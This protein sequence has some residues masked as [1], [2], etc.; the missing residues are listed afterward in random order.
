MVH[1]EQRTVLCY[2]VYKEQSR[3]RPGKTGGGIDDGTSGVVGKDQ[4]VSQTRRVASV[5][6]ES[7]YVKLE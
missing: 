3:R 6:L 2:T 4:S 7:L 1:V 5:S